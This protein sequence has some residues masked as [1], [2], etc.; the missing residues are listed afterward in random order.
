MGILVDTLFSFCLNEVMVA[1]DISHPACMFVSALFR[2]AT[3]GVSEVFAVKEELGE[4]LKE[5]AKYCKM[6]NKFDAIGKFMNMSLAMNL[7]EGTFR[8]VTGVELSRLVTAV[9]ENSERRR[10]LLDLLANH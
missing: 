8:D 7:S 10:G 4:S 3:R 5:A 1:R 2:D 6:W 9:Y